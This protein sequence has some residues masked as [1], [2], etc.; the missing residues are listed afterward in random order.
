MWC[1]D[2]EGISE[3]MKDHIFEVHERHEDMFD[4]LS[5]THNWSVC[6]NNHAWTGFE[7]RASATKVQCSNNW[8]IKA[9][10]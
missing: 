1:L 8:A 4:H 10:W 2:G 6:E 5:Y 7:P 3:Y 9:N